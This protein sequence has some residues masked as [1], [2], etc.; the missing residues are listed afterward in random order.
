[1]GLLV[2]AVVRTQDQATSLIPLAVIPQLLFAGAIVPLARMAEP[3]GDLP[4]SIF[5][6]WALAGDRHRRGHERAH[7]RRPGVRAA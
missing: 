1:M 4:T 5:A 2:S 3:R 6:H 7:R